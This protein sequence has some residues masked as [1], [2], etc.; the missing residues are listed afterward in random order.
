MRVSNKENIDIE[1]RENSNE[2]L[3]NLKKTVQTELVFP[4]SKNFGQSDPNRSSENSQP[5]VE[6]SK[7]SIYIKEHNMDENIHEGNA[8]G[9]T[10]H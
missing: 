9:Q 5:K 4:Q 8:T 10:S 2:R 1:V 7:V 3:L 6:F